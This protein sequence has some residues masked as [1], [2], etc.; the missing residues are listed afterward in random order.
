MTLS[1]ITPIKN[2]APWLEAC[3]QSCLKQDFTDWEWIWVDDHSTDNSC[4][5]ISAFADMD[6]RIQLHKNPDTGIISALEK[7][8]AEAKGNFITRMD[9][10]DVMPH[11]RLELMVE[12]LQNAPPKTVITGLVQYHSEEE[13]SPGYR[14]YEEWLNN[15]GLQNQHWQNIY[16]E[17]VVASPNWMVQKNDLIKSGGFS[18]LE[19]PEDYDLVFRWYKNQFTVKT[20]PETT[21]HWR[22]H[23]GR[24]SRNSYNYSQQK[25]FNLKIKRF[26][27]LNYTDEKP[28]VLWGTGEKARL[29][30][31]ILDR[32]HIDFIWMDLKPKK[33]P[34]GISNHPILD[35]KEIENMS[36][37]T[38]LLAVY[39]AKVE[40]E[41][42]NQYLNSQRLRKG[43]DYWFL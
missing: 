37:F 4:E 21:L 17:C 22:E 9:A 13:V 36:S 40:M 33:F 15:V 19:Y 28:L 8:L 27:Q 41:K 7:G 35:F 12:A 43:V 38:L 2:A 14:Q 10:D 5:R 29:T 30:A 1:I 16:R 34:E 20:I 32:H 24:T 6:A 25:F 31:D 23:P 26:L 39:P 18:N 3:I 11:G 42:L